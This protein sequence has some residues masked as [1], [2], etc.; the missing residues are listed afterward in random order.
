MLSP[1]FLARQQRQKAASTPGSRRGPLG[2]GAGSGTPRARPLGGAAAAGNCSPLGVLK[3]GAGERAQAARSRAAGLSCR[4]R[5]CSPATLKLT[6]SPPN[7]FSL[8]AGLP[9]VSLTLFAADLLLLLPSPDASAHTSSRRS[10]RA[11]GARHP[12]GSVPAPSLRAGRARARSRRAGSGW[13]AVRTCPRPRACSRG[14][15]GHA[16]RSGAAAA[17]RAILAGPR[18]SCKKS[19]RKMHC[20]LWGAISTD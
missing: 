16:R 3:A 6:P 4:R 1:G 17:A 19:G 11:G 20:L 14:G 2:R 10:C 5:S 12:P 9:H 15:G 8:P 18:A 13:R 7:S